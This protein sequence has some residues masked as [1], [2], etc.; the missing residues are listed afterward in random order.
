MPVMI[1]VQWVLFISVVAFQLRYFRMNLFHPVMFYLLFH[2]IVFVIHPTLAE[3]FQFHLVYEY[4]GFYPTQETQ[5]QTL[6]ISDLALV[7]FV[8]T[9]DFVT[10]RTIRAATFPAAV[11]PE[12][13]LEP[14]VVRRSL[15]VTIMLLGPIILYSIY[16]WITHPLIVQRHYGQVASTQLTQSSTTGAI[17]FT[18]TTSYIV[19][20]QFMAAPL[21]IA[22]AYVNNF[23]WRY[24]LP[25]AAY[26]LLRT[27]DGGGRV[28]FFLVGVAFGLAY[29][30]HERRIAPTR[31]VLALFAALLV[32][33][34]VLGSNRV[35]V[36]QLLGTL[37]PVE[38][39]VRVESEERTRTW[40]DR[41]YLDGEDFANFEYLTFIVYYVPQASHTYTYFTQYLNLLVQPIPR[42]IWKGKPER[43][44][45][46]MINLNSFGRFDV[47]TKSIVGDG[48]MSLGYFGVVITLAAVSFILSAAYN[49]FSMGPSSVFYTIM[50][51]VL[52]GF[53]VQW[54]RDGGTS[55]AIFLGVNLLPV[56]IWRSIYQWMMRSA[57]RTPQLGLAGMTPPARAES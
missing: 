44:L 13:P 34:G 6:F 20:A 28:A 23:R 4:M 7:V 47:L 36:K 54:F 41:S 18:N 1:A 40:S 52:L 31:K 24:C 43:D 35:L 22:L 19:Q 33:F 15:M 27:Y 11:V 32:L 49:R 42:M 12:T 53:S 14:R 29:L 3:I 8:V 45:I 17:L 26:I 25:F 56:W 30:A 38:Q 55:I 39:S 51:C 16:D 9:S 10:R 2:A 46:P 21:L 5:I 48:W 50:Y 37:S 57:R